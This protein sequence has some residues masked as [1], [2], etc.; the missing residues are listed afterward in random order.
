MVVRSIS[1]TR[2]RRAATELRSCCRD[3]RLRRLDVRVRCNLM[4]SCGPLRHRPREAA[5]RAPTFEPGQ[6]PDGRRARDR[7]RA[8]GEAACARRRHGSDRRACRRSA[9]AHAPARGRAEVPRRQ[10]SRRLLRELQRQLAVLHVVRKSFRG[11]EGPVSRKKQAPKEYP[12]EPELA[13]I[14]RA[15]RTELMRSQN[16]GLAKGFMFPSRTGT[17]RTP[18]SLDAAWGDCF[19]SSTVPRPYPRSRGHDHRLV[20]Q[21]SPQGVLVPPQSSRARPSR[22]A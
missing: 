9:R 21:V 19:A 18:N 13:E 5:H 6:P 8:Q 7:V 20:D 12:V 17:L 22:G 1:F 16:P 2:T 11:V 15:H 4:S 14:L 10:P 3:G